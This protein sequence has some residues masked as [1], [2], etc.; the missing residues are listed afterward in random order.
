MKKNAHV[1]FCH[2]D[3]AAAFNLTT[4]DAGEVVKLRKVAG[5][6]YL[7]VKFESVTVHNL[8]VALFDEAKKAPAAPKAG[9]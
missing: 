9:E 2:A 7:T 3:H 1:H 4:E 6:T 8:S 5:S